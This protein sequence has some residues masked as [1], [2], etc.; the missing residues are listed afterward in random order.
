M[1]VDASKSTYPVTNFSIHP[2]ITPIKF[3][4]KDDPRRPQYEK[5]L[6]PLNET[7]RNAVVAGIA[8]VL[9]SQYVYPKLAEVIVV[10][11]NNHL[12]AGDYD[13]FTD[14]S[15]FAQQLTSDIHSAGHDLHMVTALV[16]PTG[17][18]LEDDKPR[19]PEKHLEHLRPINF[20]FGTVVID[21]DTIP[22]RSIATL[23][24]KGFMPA[25]AEFAIDWREIRKAI[26]DILTEIADADALLVD[27]RS[28][29]GG[30]PATVAFILSY[31]LDNG[32][33]M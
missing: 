1:I 8:D 13:H 29:N 25:T 2:I 28:N 21:R 30:D 6:A 31:L 27:L 33:G 5:A 15:E 14:P 32:P 12:T 24:I 4:P 9:R 20:G 22:G 26:R 3:I 17:H 23:P 10:S 19:K 16:E 7:R 11:L 18:P